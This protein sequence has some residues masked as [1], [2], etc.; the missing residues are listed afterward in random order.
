MKLRL[1]RQRRAREDGGWMLPSRWESVKVV[2]STGLKN[3]TGVFIHTNWMNWEME[4]LV[5][6]GR[7]GLGKLSASV[8]E[9]PQWDSAAGMLGPSPLPA[10]GPQPSPSCS[11]ILSCWTF[12][13]V[14][15]MI[16]TGVVPA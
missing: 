7:W 11:V 9:V 2:T 12:E 10:A 5:G 13:V 4:L 3:D 6:A 16:V 15:F 8:D 14:S 1:L